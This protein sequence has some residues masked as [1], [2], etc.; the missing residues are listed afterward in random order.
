MDAAKIRPTNIASTPIAGM[1]RKKESS[2]QIDTRDKLQKSEGKTFF[3]K[4][5]DFVRENI[6]GEKE[7]EASSAGSGGKIGV[8]EACS[9]DY[10]SIKPVVAA[11]TAICGAAGAVIG[12]ATTETDVSKLPRQTVEL[13]W[14]EPVMGEKYLGEVP[15]DYYESVDNPHKS[16][17]KEFQTA[18]KEMGQNFHRG[19]DPTRSVFGSAPLRTETGDVMMTQRQEVFTGRGELEVNWETKD[20]NDPRMVGLMD[21]PQFDTHKVVVGRT[22]DGAHVTRDVIDGIQH[23]FAPDI[24]NDEVG[25]YKE[26]SVEFKTPNPWEHAGMGLAYGMMVGLGLGTIVGVIRKVLHK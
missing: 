18:F 22:P 17:G 5:K 25:S 26:P 10:G 20:I 9:S 13:K 21:D 24:Q 15:R 4:V 23:K 19:L 14:N 2:A 6:T 12:Y 3:S 16:L 8:K 7:V 11:S 1:A